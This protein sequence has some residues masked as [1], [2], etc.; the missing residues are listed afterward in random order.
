MN[1]KY[2]GTL[3][4]MN[5]IN[6]LFFGMTKSNPLVNEI[7][8][9]YQDQELFDTS[10]HDDERSINKFFS[11]T[12]KGI[13]FF[14]V[15][16]KEELQAAVKV[17]RTQRKA[18]KKGLI[19]PTC[20]LGKSNRKIEQILAK[21]NCKEILPADI[22]AKSAVYKIDFW[23]KQI[24][25][26]AKRYQPESSKE[27]ISKVE[28]EKEKETKTSSVIF[29][30]PIEQESDIWI[31]KHKTDAK[32]ILRRWL[33]RVMGPSPQ[34]CKWEEVENSTNKSQKTWKLRFTSD[35]IMFYESEGVWL[36]EGAKPEFDWK[37]KRWNFSSDAPRLYFLEKDKDAV[38][39]FEIAG[40]N[41]EVCENS[42]KAMAK[43]ASII[44]TFDTSYSFEKKKEDEE[45]ETSIESDAKTEAGNLEGDVKDNRRDS[46]HMRGDSKNSVESEHGS[47]GS[48]HEDDKGGH[49][50]GKVKDKGHSDKEREDKDNVLDEDSEIEKERKKSRDEVSGRLEGKVQKNEA[51]DKK[52]AAKK[53]PKQSETQSAERKSQSEESKKDPE[54]KRN[55]VLE[56]L[57]NK[58]ND[59]EA[60]DYSP[61]AQLRKKKQ[62]AR[63]KEDQAKKEEAQAKSLDEK[64]E[65]R[66][67]DK[68][69]DEKE[70]EKPDFSST[71]TDKREAADRERGEFDDA[72]AGN[73]GGKSST[74][75]IDRSP[76]GSKSQK[77]A[78]Q[79]KEE[80]ERGEF[81]E[82]PKN[83]L[84]GKGS[85]DQ[86]DR[87][88]L[89][90]KSQKQAD[91][92][93][94]ERE[95][96]EFKEGAK[97]D[98]G[99]KS[100]TDQIDRSPLGSKTQKQNQ[101]KKDPRKSNFKENSQN[102][103]GGKGSTDQIDRSHY[104]NKKQI[105]HRKENKKIEDSE[106]DLQS[107][108]KKEKIVPTYGRDD[109]LDE[110]LGEAQYG[111]NKESSY[112]EFAENPKYAE[113]S[114]EDALDPKLDFGVDEPESKEGEEEKS[115]LEKILAKPSEVSTESGRL[116]VALEQSTSAGNAIS[117]L[118]DF[119]DFYPDE[120]MVLAPKS[121]LSVGE[122]VRAKVSLKYNSSKKEVVVLGKIS[123]V[124]SFDDRLDHLVI[125][126]DDINQEDYEQFIS[127][128]NDRQ[129]QINDFI[130][131]AKGF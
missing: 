10:F 129:S 6:L 128:Y 113:G 104:D 24:T 99:G 103:L 89:G 68:T 51:L 40:T 63:L 25:G 11:H 2:K 7:S 54:E 96:G 28:I 72:Q 125:D 93:K 75:Q 105:D 33:L 78:Q 16:S 117:F 57:L 60:V 74:D 41:L 90:S 95:R 70:R 14:T 18:I 19:K 27:A 43:E 29:V 107:Y 61:E 44:K 52:E 37:M 116:K 88:P 91:K 22:R 118:C 100:S 80:R 131:R 97:N 123:E 36:F 9:Y 8:N 67:K 3:N 50:Q 106:S 39:R 21:Y 42:K 127:L 4:I 108:K 85:T 56:Q 112:N 45:D 76:L 55:P 110:Q 65:L 47:K 71:S 69:P 73:L 1:R 101:D 66:K 38:M 34:V 82:G 53:D 124:E 81:K 86:I 115:E 31:V 111:S 126:L 62:E 64:N 87:S 121:S 30:E 120:L 48:F 12:P 119:E 23:A 20:I 59:V 102:D 94:K 17:L 109:A 122:I 130:E 49:L 5:V 35:E 58:K 15:S 46:S 32:K 79:E 13:F 77:R 98:L 83:D 84:G 92:E 114:V 26:Q